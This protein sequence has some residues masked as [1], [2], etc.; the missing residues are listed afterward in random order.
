LKPE[1][2]ALNL[3]ISYTA[4]EK[5]VGDTFGLT[6]LIAGQFLNKK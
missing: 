5:V 4:C 6:G 1:K 3:S 2:V